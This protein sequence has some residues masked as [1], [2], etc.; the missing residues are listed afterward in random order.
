MGL[1]WERPAA[2]WNYPMR[3]TKH[4]DYALRVLIYL[5]S[6]K[7]G[8]VTTQSIADA[9]DISAS[10]LQKVV[11]ALG[12]LKLVSLFRGVNG[13]I[14][15]CV[16]PAKISV[17]A[18]VR[19]LDDEDAWIECFSEE[20]NECV[21]STACGLKGALRTAQEAFYKSLDPI[22]IAD[23]IGRRANALKKLTGG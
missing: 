16:D 18:V 20:T 8:R 21:V 5:G 4:T 22:S 10:H 9:F 14:E 19:A 3:V 13:G 2:P 7:A 12:E 1:P 11:R 23:V 15:L 17:G 6:R